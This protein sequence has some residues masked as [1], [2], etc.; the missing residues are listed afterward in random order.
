MWIVVDGLRGPGDSSLFRCDSCVW[1][2]ADRPAQSTPPQNA[3]CVGK[4]RVQVWTWDVLVLHNHQISRLETAR[5]QFFLFEPKSH[6][7]GT[8]DMFRCIPIRAV[9][10]SLHMRMSRESNGGRIG[11]S[12]WRYCASLCRFLHLSL[13]TSM[14]T[15]HRVPQWCSMPKTGP[16]WVRRI[17]ILSV[18]PLIF[19]RLPIR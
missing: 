7:G 11:K 18:D 9:L 14:K 13:R 1:I 8:S 10:S 15:T 6:L 19:K 4:W 16:F 12:W 2:V 17:A 3:V 5:R